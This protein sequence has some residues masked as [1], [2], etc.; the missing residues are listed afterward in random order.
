MSAVGEDVVIEIPHGKLRG[1]R[2]AQ[3]TSFKGI[4]YAAPPFGERRLRAP[5][6][7]VPWPGV[8]DATAFGPTAPR[9][10]YPPP[11]EVLFDEPVLPG[12]DCLNLNVWTRDTGAGGCPVLVWIHGGAFRN[13][14]AAAPLYDGTNF[15]VDGLVFVSLNYR[16]GAD[17]FLVLDG[18]ECNRGL[19]DQ[20]A[21]LEWIRENIAA[22]GGD[23]G[24]VTICGESA[25]AMSV[26]SL[27][28]MP[29]ARGLFHRAIAQSGG[30][31][32]ALDVADAH[33]IAEEMATRLGIAPTRDALVATPL[34]DLLTV[35]RQLSFEIA[36]NPD[37]GRWGGVALDLMPFEPTVDGDILPARPIDAIAA[38]AGADVP[39]LA[40]ATAEEWRLFMVPTGLIGMLGDSHVAASLASYGVAGGPV[41]VLYE[42][43]EGSPGD[44]FC[45]IATDW[46]VRIPLIRLAE[47]R[48][49]AQAPTYVYEL[50]WRS[51]QFQGQ[52]GACHGLDLPFV[53]GTL[54]TQSGR[55]FTGDS[56]PR[57][58]TEEMRAAWVAFASARDPGW[59]AYEDGTRAEMVFDEGSHVTDD[60]EAA[61]RVVWEGHR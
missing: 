11:F 2:S 39:L 50:A 44:R 36:A 21:A 45:A 56:P 12:A 33:R 47:A 43:L 10:G 22:F 31:H 4:P 59:P 1:R 17:G 5:A 51:P 18:T 19:L 27:L 48:A 26:C 35:Q 7:V 34:D 23:P 15:A 54:D 61:R 16:L 53:F 57:R 32:H 9:T 42:E 41:Q 49:R 28:A 14:T 58:L 29:R 60:P 6:P 55:A 3:A 40:G 13:G 20:I 38:G 8:R 46:Y 37:P 30:G 25:G 52:L 24:N